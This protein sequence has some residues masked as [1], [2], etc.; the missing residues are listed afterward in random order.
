VYK[1]SPQDVNS[2]TP[3]D[4]SLGDEVRGHLIDS[5]NL[6]CLVSA[7]SVLGSELCKRCKRINLDTVFQKKHHTKRGKPLRKLGPTEKWSVNSC[8]LCKL[9]LQFV[10]LEEENSKGYELRTLSSN[11]ILERGWQ[12]IDTTMLTIDR[13]LTFLLKQPEHSS[14]VR[15]IQPNINPALIKDWLNYC[16][17]SAC[18][19]GDGPLSSEST[20][21]PLSA[22]LSFKVIDCE[23]RQIVDGCRA[24]YV[25][26][27]YVWG[28]G[29]RSPR[30]FSS[31]TAS[32]A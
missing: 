5:T 29:E 14:V 18:S 22:I 9:M 11:R 19:V 6:T 26:L 15:L 12:A 13:G 25:A 8:S 30:V 7:A 20:T 27:S 1:W 28:V 23:M 31:V 10:P 2:R 21:S 16:H 24:Q 32:A 3:G 4:H 17:S